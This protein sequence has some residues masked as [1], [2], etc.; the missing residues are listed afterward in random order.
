VRA[1]EDI[2]VVEISTASAAA[3]AGRLFADAGGTVV[4]VEPL[5]GHFLRHEGPFLRDMP[6]SETSAAH[7]HV[8]ASKRSVTVDFTRP[9]ERVREL[10][11][12]A[13]VFLTDLTD[14]ALGAARLTWDALTAANPALLMTQ[15]TPFG[16]TGPYRHYSATNLISMALGAQLKVTGDPG[17]PPL[18]NF[19]SQA[20]YQAGLAAFA[21]TLANLLLRDATGHGEH[22]DL[23]VQDV[24][25]NNLEGR[26]LTVN[27]DVMA[28]RAGLNVSAVY[29]VY[30][31]A[32]GWVFLS[33]FAPALWEQLK[34]VAQIEQ[35]NDER[36]STQAG[37]LDSNDELQAVLTTWTLSKTSDELRAFSQ[38][39]FPL[40][41]AETPERLLRS[42]QWR[43][44]RFVQ[45]VTHE[46]AGEISV[47]GPP[48]LDASAVPLSPAPLLGEGNAELLPDV[49]G[50]LC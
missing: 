45:T 37:R 34:S 13:D 17:K 35:L 2:R 43:N 28:E 11:L 48:W 50:A 31:C 27:L 4:L 41:V 18:C 22:L 7:L 1:L 14:D 40:T 32:D 10:V 15:V 42:E 26:Y 25:A 5:E 23:S 16:C 12:G 33:A 49:P 29:G 47:L 19:G 38:R 44:R 20:E 46:R 9:P 30:P 24:V 36:F 8:N 3:F 21:G 39:G 6:D